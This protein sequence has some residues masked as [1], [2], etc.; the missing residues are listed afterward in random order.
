M[1]CSSEHKEEACREEARKITL[2]DDLL[3]HACL[4]QLREVATTLDQRFG[5]WESAKS[6]SRGSTAYSEVNT[7]HW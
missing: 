4:P 3:G 6:V 7:G 1:Q 5:S 2:K